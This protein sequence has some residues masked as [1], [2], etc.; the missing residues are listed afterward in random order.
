M[1]LGAPGT[2]LRVC[3]REE[4]Q[5]GGF[6]GERRARAAGIVAASIDGGTARFAGERRARVAGIAAASVDGGQSSQN[7]A[8]PYCGCLQ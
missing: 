1:R 2:R 3:G 8:P 7:R 6:A 5:G 4:S